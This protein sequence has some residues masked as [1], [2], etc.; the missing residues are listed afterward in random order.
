MSLDIFERND[1]LVIEAFRNGDFDYLEGASDIDETDFFR[2]LIERSLL[3]QLAESYPNPREKNDVP[4]WLHLG[5]YLTMNFHGEHA[6]HALPGLLCYGGLINAL[7]A[8][9]GH[10]VK[11]PVTGKVT[12]ECK[13]YNHKN[14][15]SRETPCDQDTSR[16]FARETPAEALWTWYESSVV[17]IL[18]QHKAFDSEGIFIGDG[19]YLFVPDNP[20]YEGSELLWFD[21]HNKPAEAPKTKAGR[22][23]KRQRRCYKLVSLLHTNRARD[24]FIYAGLAVV[25]PSWHESPVFFAMLDRIATEHP[26]L[27]KKVILDRG[28]FSGEDLHHHKKNHGI[29]F[30][31][32]L[33]KGTRAYADAMQ[34]LGE[35]RWQPYAKPAPE[36]KEPPPNR[37]AHIIKR[38]AARQRTL[39]AKKAM[40]VEPVPP[41]KQ[42][43]KSEVGVL[44]ALTSW[45]S[46]QW[47]FH[48]V[49]N[50][51]TDEQGQVE[52]WFL[53]S[54]EPIRNPHDKRDEYGIRTEI[55]ERHRQLKCFW[56]ITDFHSRSLSLVCNHVIFVALTYS[57]IQLYL[58]RQRE[59]ALANR[60]NLQKILRARATYVIIYY[61]NYY[62][63]LTP[64]EHQELVVTLN[65][66]AAKKILAK[67]RKLK[68]QLKNALPNPRP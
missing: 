31:V 27:I 12:L 44:E 26:G 56:D 25:P 11:H 50:R 51:E 20:A 46:F 30:L 48:L 9:A 8:E 39:A 41:P 63:V 15:Y 60:A 40:R 38:E 1:E 35:V 55:E 32:P 58:R 23:G 54:T 16:K 17:S 68:A 49:A 52:H 4:V 3:K 18:R 13:G 67:T 22:A 7:G 43:A 10:R 42:S 59:T 45:K 24:Y 19:S 28:F 6:F 64:L 5:H 29:D 53:L 66:T 62:A 14:E 2:D 57:L 61:M 65:K 33:K 34:L 36:P 37:P 47:P 21:E